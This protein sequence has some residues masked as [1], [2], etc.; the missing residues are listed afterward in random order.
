MP[1][2]LLA[3]AAGQNYRIIEREEE[4]RVLQ[5]VDELHEQALQ[6]FAA[7]AVVLARTDDRVRRLDWQRIEES[8]RLHRFL[9]DLDTLPRIHALSIADAQGRVRASSRFFPVPPTDIADRDYFTAQKTR[10]AGIYVGLPH[11]GRLDRSARFDLSRRRTTPDGGFDGIIDVSVSTGHFSKFYS[12]LSREK[13]FTALLLRSDG[14]VL[15][16]YPASPAR[17][18]SPHRRLMQ[19]IAA[20]PQKGLLRA[21]SQSDGIRRI[22]GYERVGDYPLYVVFGIPVQGVKAIWRANLVN[23]L[24]FAIPASLALVLMAMFAGRQLLRQQ[25]ASWR[26]QNT[27]RRLRREAD[28]RAQT[29]AELRQAQKMEAL[30]QLTGGVA[31]DFNNLLTVLQG[32]LEILAEQVTQEGPRA[33]IA[34]AMKT[35][36]RGEKL[37]AQLL[38]FARR[39]PLL[40]RSLDLNAQLN[41][42]TEMLARTVGGRVKLETELAADLWA[43]RADA[44]QLELAV[45]NLA[46]NARD[47]MPEG[48]SLRIRTFNQRWRDG[49]G[50]PADESVGLEVSDSGT[51]MPPEVLARAFEP[52]FTTKE[53]GRGTGLGLSMVYDFARRSGGTAT[54]ESEL[55]G[56]TRVTLVLLRGKLPEEAPAEQ[57]GLPEAGGA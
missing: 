41:G 5:T 14:N 8:R 23:Y 37:T 24:L 18:F 39:Q 17:T 28:R 32:N 1:L 48:G 46:I 55:G 11:T 6:A 36:E 15:V 54:I 25:V 40:I 38:A 43:A 50:T 4:A 51:G 20:D 21:R 52:F 30:G 33:K 19:A 42:M 56:G 3:T 31:H 35:I 47:A 29:E 16:R 49:H 53:P 27:A 44:N 22:Y 10:G 13:G 45:I 12:T 7:Y 57:S 2:L 9:V 34:Q 26:W